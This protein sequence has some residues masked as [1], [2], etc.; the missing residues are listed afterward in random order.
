MHDNT[1]IELRRRGTRCALLKWYP[2]PL[3]EPAVDPAVLECSALERTSRI[4]LYSVLKL[5][6]AVSSDGLLREWARLWLRLSLAL[7]IPSVLALPVLVFAI[8]QIQEIA[9]ALSIL[10]STLLSIVTTLV[11]IA[12][13]VATVITLVY[14]AVKSRRQQQAASADRLRRENN[15]TNL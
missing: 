2:E 7:L 12:A 8:N 10:L 5:E 6:Y 15:L 3:T 13:I 11:T 14:A 4:L 1:G 9:T